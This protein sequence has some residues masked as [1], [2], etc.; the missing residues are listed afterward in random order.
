MRYLGID[1]GEK[2]TGVAISDEEGRI[3]FPHA[4]LQT[5]TLGKSLSDLM[6]EKQVNHFVL[7]RS[8]T[9]KGEEN[10]IMVSVHALAEHL[11]DVGEVYFED[12]R[13]TSQQATR[14]QGDNEMNDASAAALILQS[15]LDKRQPKE[16]LPDAYT[17]SREEK[18]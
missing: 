11:R 13:Y 2:R 1:Y 9:G 12:E 4:V 10:P 14:L 7:G 16:P 3:A 5:Y 18:N 15:F 17:V 8:I 6:K